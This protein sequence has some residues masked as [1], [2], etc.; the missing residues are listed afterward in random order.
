M[1]DQGPRPERLRPQGGVPQRAQEEQEEEQEVTLSNVDKNSMLIV[2]YIGGKWDGR[3][4][5]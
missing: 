5:K 4:L 2:M 1:L 3:A